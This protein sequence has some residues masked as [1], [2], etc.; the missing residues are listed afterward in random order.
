MQM[1]GSGE[2]K[3]SNQ[4]LLTAATLGFAVVELDVTIVNVGLE[5]I[6]ISLGSGVVKLQ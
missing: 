1:T 6:G 5:E 3:H 4:L 2:T